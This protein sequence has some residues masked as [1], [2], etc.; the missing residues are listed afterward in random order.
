MHRQSKSIIKY[1]HRNKLMERRTGQLPRPSVKP[2]VFLVL[3]TISQMPMSA[4]SPGERVYRLVAP[5]VFL[6]ETRGQTGDR[7]A[8]GTAFVVAHGKLVTN[9]HVV[10]G[11]TPFV[12]GGGLAVECRLERIDFG[13]DLALLEVAGDIA[14]PPLRI[15]VTD[16]TPG[17]PIYAIGN[18]SGLE[19]TISNGLYTGKRDAT[20]REL[21]QISA[22]ISPGSS[23]G[24]VVNG[25]GEV[26]GVVTMSLTDAQN[27]NFAV[28][29]SALRAL[30]DSETGRSAVNAFA[31]LERLE[32]EQATLP[33][34]DDENSPWQSKQ[35]E[36]NWVLSEVA[37][38]LPDDPK[39]MTQLA[40]AAELNDTHIASRAA[41]R[42]LLKSLALSASDL[43]R[44]TEVLYTAL[45]YETD[46]GKR[47]GL[48]RDALLASERAERKRGNPT[49]EQRHLIGELDKIVGRRDA[50]VRRWKELLATCGG[51]SAK[52]LWSLCLDAIERKS[53]AEA[54]DYFGQ[55]IAITTPEPQQHETYADFLA[56][57]GEHSAAGR[58]YLHAADGYT[59]TPLQ[60]R[61][62]CSAAVRF[63][64]GGE[65][66]LH[67]RSARI[68][69][70]LGSQVAESDARVGT[71]HRLLASS[72]IGRG[73]YD[74]AIA[75]AK[76][77]IAIAND[78]A[79]AYHYL[80]A[81]YD[82]LGRDSEAVQA[83][84][85]AIRL[86]DGRWSVMHS[87][88]GSAYF[89][90]ENWPLARAAY[91]KAA[92]LNPSDTASAYNV[93]MCYI[94]EGYTRDAAAWLEEVLRRHPQHPERDE[95]QKMINKFLR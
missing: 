16:L 21:L 1:A 78:D 44:L 45:Q 2:I 77:A 12:V 72:L 49:C 90:I 76:N 28:P 37:R 11:G 58:A 67:I 41:R 56:E 30:L 36:I 68:C 38:D 5:S 62:I 83:A 84:K 51:N 33:Y 79:W 74:E 23:G 95:I 19:K 7:I 9:A 61:A 26:V 54:N 91:A 13:N 71:A 60:F 8:Q 39:L 25:A 92:E 57:E 47:L 14:A 82:V 94:N 40:S 86:S 46:E 3:I 59:E 66:D 65:T 4:E 10:A 73:V 89:D 63:W 88:L 24:P 70:E 80:A 69:I 52:S 29:A 27:L 42:A 75:H 81:A 43:F 87:T 6:I 32:R 53:R 22:P 55:L 18:P 48:A 31:T 85:T 15:A 64:S 34:S 20:E 35:T 50:A 93:A 17:A